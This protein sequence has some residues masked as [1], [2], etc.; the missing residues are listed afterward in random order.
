MP[1]HADKSRDPRL[2]GPVL[3]LIPA[4]GGSKG[5][6]RKNVRP[7][8]GKPLLLYTCETAK[9]SR[10]L[11]RIVCSTED[12][13]IAELARASGVEVPFARP[14]ELALDKTP[15]IDVVR[16]ALQTLAL[17]GYMPSILVLLQPTAP[18]RNE[19]HVD[20]AVELLR[21][22]T[23]DSVVSVVEVPHQFH[24]GFILRLDGGRLM[25]YEEG[26]EGR[27]R[28][29]D[30]EPAYS[31]NGAV[32]ACWRQTVEAFGNL[33]GKDCRPYLMTAEES[34]NLDDEDDWGRAEMLLM[35]SDEWSQAG[36][37]R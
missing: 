3:G 37:G 23:A 27:T 20:E 22:S 6:P 17:D 30:L 28:R 29:Q 36:E 32:Y 19:R 26:G 25:F 7:L 16:H 1:G 8:A 15:M 14:M 10:S 4:R 11:G 35:R 21:S 12:E 33:Y 9:R 5:I 34:V 2:E 18:L 24:P 13:E 31:R